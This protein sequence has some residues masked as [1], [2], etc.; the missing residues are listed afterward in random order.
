MKK[1]LFI[2]RDG[3]I[4]QEP[5]DYQVDRLDKIRLVP[6]VI[7][8]LLRLQAAGYRFVMVT[9]QDGLG[10]AAF[11]QQDFDLCQ[12]FILDL[13]ATQGI[14]FEE[15]LICPHY[16]EEGCFC[17][18]PSVGLVLPWLTR[19]DWDRQ[20]TAVIGDRDTDMELAKAMGIPALRIASPFADGLSW[21]AIADHFLRR[22]RT[23]VVHRQTK[24][25]DIQVTVNLD[26]ATE[27]SIQTGIGF[28]DH[29]L[30]QIARHAGI[31]L[32]IKGKGDLH[33]DDH[34]TVEDVGIALGQALKKA[35]G[36]KRGLARYGFTLPMD[37]V[38][39]EALIDL[40][41]RPYFVWQASFQRASIASL[42]TEMIPHFFRSLAENLGANL[43]MSAQGDNDHHIAEGLFKA[44]ARALKQALVREGTELP[45]TKGVL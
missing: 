7:P 25:T 11:P 38:R 17:R 15:I 43:H 9:N 6:G 39:A 30:E 35:L 37:E 34:H 4:N 42:S 44:F 21:E 3:T 40:S 26:R 2:D 36:D 1:I 24:E 28:F 45:S 5:V 23:A 18:K 29:M 10:T 8:A 12:N 33:I 16:K 19:S 22:D 31:S 32:A 20:D 41:G 13:L 27:Q 14:H